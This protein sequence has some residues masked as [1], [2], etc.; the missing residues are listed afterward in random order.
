MNEKFS[1]PAELK[2]K[3][4]RV[5]SKGSLSESDFVE[6]CKLGI[7]LKNISLQEAWNC[8]SYCRFSA[9]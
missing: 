8:L 7:R 9:N 4:D 3:L 5:K 6:V 2:Q 1:I